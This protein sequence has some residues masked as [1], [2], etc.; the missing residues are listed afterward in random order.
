MNDETI[1]MDGGR[2][3]KETPK[4]RV[5]LRDGKSVSVRGSETEDETVSMSKRTVEYREEEE[6]TRVITAAKAMA[7]LVEKK[8]RNRGTVYRLNAELT[9]LGRSKSSDIVLTDDTVSTD[10]A[11][12]RREQSG[13]VLYDLVT[14]NGTFVNEQK[15]VNAPLKENDQI[16]I[17]ETVLVLKIVE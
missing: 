10:H 4:D 3:K 13:F 12:I 15:I 16:R 6:K 11:K 9:T 8:G 1:S 17:G 14:A 7:W 5:V 2:G